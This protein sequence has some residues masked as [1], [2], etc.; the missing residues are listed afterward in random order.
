MSSPLHPA[1]PPMRA[2]C[3]GCGACCRFVR[4]SFSVDLIGPGPGPCPALE[5]EDGR[6]WC[7]LV[8]HPLKWIKL[9]LD[10][11]PEWKENIIAGEIQTRL[12]YG[13]AL[14]LGCDSEDGIETLAPSEPFP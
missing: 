11:W 9:P 7:G 2:P 12:A 10:G 3:N 1:K 6:A 14:G 4:C 5:Y 13:L 8:R